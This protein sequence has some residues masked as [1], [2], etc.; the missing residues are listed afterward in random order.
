M[1]YF[2]WDVSSLR[3]PAENA[4]PARLEPGANMKYYNAL[5]VVSPSLATRKGCKML[6]GR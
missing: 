3:N 2:G 1:Y 6:A 4:S 5:P